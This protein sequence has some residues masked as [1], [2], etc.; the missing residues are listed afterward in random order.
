MSYCKTHEHISQ[1]GCTLCRSGAAKRGYTPSNPYARGTSV[2]TL[3][4][5]GG[6]R[7]LEELSLIPPSEWGEEEFRERR[8]RLAERNLWNA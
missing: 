2:K 6:V 7:T 5:H 4:D 3:P 8:I 1:K